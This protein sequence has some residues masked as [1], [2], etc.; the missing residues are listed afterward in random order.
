MQAH[1]PPPTRVL[2]VVDGFWRFVKHLARSELAPAD[3][4][5]AVV[6]WRIAHLFQQPLQ[7]AGHPPGAAMAMDGRSLSRQPADHQQLPARSSAQAA[8][9]VGLFRELGQAAQGSR[10]QTSRPPPPQSLQVGGARA[11]RQFADQPHQLG[12]GHVLSILGPP[13]TPAEPLSP[14][15][16][17][18]G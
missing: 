13:P 10:F 8:P 4:T 12:E 11:V 1:R 6:D 15:G 18:A 3:R 17:F 7:Q 5:D 2:H 14:L 16:F 9:G